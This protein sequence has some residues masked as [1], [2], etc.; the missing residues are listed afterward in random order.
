MRNT[1]RALS[2]IF[3]PTVGELVDE[4]T[5]W[6]NGGLGCSSLEGFLPYSWVNLTDVLWVEQFVGTGF[7]IGEVTAASEED[8]AKDFADF[9]PNFQE[10]FGMS[11]FKIFITSGI[12][13]GRH[14]P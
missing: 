3:Q 10:I 13:A 4:I 1:S 2:F 7:L 14:A 6:L 9:F 8:I 12:Y 5:I 11:K